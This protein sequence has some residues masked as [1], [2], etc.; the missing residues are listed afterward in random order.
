MHSWRRQL[1]F[2]QKRANNLGKQKIEVKKE[3][4]QMTRYPKHCYIKIHGFSL[5][6]NLMLKIKANL[7]KYVT[8]L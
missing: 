3:S 5:Q 1:Q 2:A 8:I 4:K 6:Y 7:T